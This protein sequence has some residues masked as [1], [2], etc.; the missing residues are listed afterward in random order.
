MGTFGGAL[1][2]RNIEVDNDNFEAEITGEVELEDNVLVIKKI[3]VLYYI[4]T[5]KDN[6]E[7]IERVHK[8]HKEKCPVYRSLY[9]GI[10][11]NTQYE[12][13]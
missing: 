7:T 9:K 3:N 4:K 2:A 13:M 12:I 11:F 6:L 10:E 8:F 5:N 1:K